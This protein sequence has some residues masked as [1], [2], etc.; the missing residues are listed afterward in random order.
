[1]DRTAILVL[2]VLLAAG[3][4][5]KPRI[6][7]GSKNF[8]EQVLLGEI[9]ARHIERR[10]GLEV[11]R[12]LNLGG[13][14]LAHEALKGGSIDLYPEYTGTALTAVLKQAAVR[15][16]KAALD[17]VREGYQPWGLEWLPPLGFNNSF[18]MVV[19]A[20]SAREQGL[21][22]L[23]DAARRPGP[24][25]LG[26]GY[27]FTQRP[28]GLSGLVQ[29]YGLRVA[30]DPVAMDLGLLYPALQAKTIEMAAANAT[31]GM[32]ARPEFVVLDDDR[33]Y[34]PPY[35]CAIVVRQD[36]LARYP[37]LRAALAELSDRIPDSAI[38]RMNGLV[39]VEHR[40]AAEVARDFL[41]EWR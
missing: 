20:G 8:T 27:E 17:R 41:N 2:I 25:R 28:D 4:S 26:V 11:N 22:T 30:R 13:T 18:A 6:V 21:R 24:W 36:T 23:S 32:L 10:L 38:R 3:C 5:S 12:K 40:P 7:V 16:A 35:E 15:D 31:D 39:D 33:H 29:S 14:L 34:F 19:R 9:V 1:M 37:R